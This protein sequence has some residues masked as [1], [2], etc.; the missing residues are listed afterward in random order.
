MVKIRTLLLYDDQGTRTATLLLKRLKKLCLDGDSQIMGVDWAALSPSLGERL[1]KASH[2]VA[3]LS[4]G[5]AGSPWFAFTAGFALGKGLPF[6]GF[7]AA[8]GMPVF[9]PCISPI[10]GEEELDAYFTREKAEWPSREAHRQAKFALLDMGVPFSEES[11]EQCIR[12]RKTAAAALFLEAGFSPDARDNTG[13]PLICLAARAGDRH[14]TNMLLKAGASVNLQALDR[15]STALIDCAS[16]KHRDIMADLLAA[17]A[18]VNLKSKDGQ[19]ALIIA[20]GLNDEEAA[21][22]LLKAGAN[23]DEPDS[24]GASARKYAT[25]FNKPGM[26]ELFK[27]YAGS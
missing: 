3:V 19:S 15:G 26:V 17:G 27:A 24:L 16:G 8:E 9:S 5:A 13:V 4:P 23:P 1:A 21:A 2:I 14:I 22:L 20:V 11:F 12:E 18:D 6:L 10:P 7:G 25:L